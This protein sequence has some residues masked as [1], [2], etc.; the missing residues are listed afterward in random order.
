[1]VDS[2]VNSCRREEFLPFLTL[3][4]CDTETVEGCAADLE[5]RW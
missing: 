4:P 2:P 3:V 1:M 5:S